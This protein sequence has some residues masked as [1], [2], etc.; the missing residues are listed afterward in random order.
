MNIHT[1]LIKIIIFKEILRFIRN[2]TSFA[3]ADFGEVVRHLAEISL[4]SS[5]KSE[6]DHSDLITKFNLLG[7]TKQAISTL[8]EPWQTRNLTPD[9]LLLATISKKGNYLFYKL[10]VN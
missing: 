5:D 8:I 3:E 10:R 9:F 1:F 2:S 7:V 6:L 4:I